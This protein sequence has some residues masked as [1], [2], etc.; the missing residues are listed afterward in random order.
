MTIALAPPEQLAKAIGYYGAANLA[1]NA[2]APAV[3]EAV[4]ERFGFTPVFALAAGSGAVAGFVL[5]RTLPRGDPDHRAPGV[6]L[7][8]LVARPSSLYRMIAIGTLWG[9]AFSAMFV[10]HQPFP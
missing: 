9:V 6:G 8:A 3:A 4:A 2:V 1:M 10:F 5:T 7:Y